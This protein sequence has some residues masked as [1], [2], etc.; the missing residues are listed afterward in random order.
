MTR[1]SVVSR[2]RLNLEQQVDDLLAGRAVQVAGRLVGEQDRRIVG[3]RARDRHALLL[4]ARQLR[5]IVMAAIARARLRR[6]A[7]RPARRRRRH[8]GDLHRHEH[9]LERGQR[10]Q[11]MEELEH[12]PDARAAQPRQRVLARAR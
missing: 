9:V 12:E 11:Q 4:A 5:R 7:P 2:D 3:Q 1:T 6:A 8:A 10:R